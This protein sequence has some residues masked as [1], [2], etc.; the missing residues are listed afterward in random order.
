MPL[1]LG[2]AA[3]GLAIYELYPAKKPRVR[4]WKLWLFVAV[5]SVLPDIDYA[6]GLVYGGNGNLFHRGITHS[7]LFALIA[8]LFFFLSG[9]KWPRFFPPLGFVRCTLVVLSHTVMDMLFSPSGASLFYPL[10]IVRSSGHSGFWDL[11]RITIVESHKDAG[12]IF[13]CAVLIIAARIA[14]K[15]SLS[16]SRRKSARK[17]R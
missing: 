14:G 8:G 1:P 7:L 15:L 12:I 17:P 2:H 3:V 4:W 9:K 16:A 11:A 6:I 13:F 10:E 5:L